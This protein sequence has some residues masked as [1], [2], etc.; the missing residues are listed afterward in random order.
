MPIVV[1]ENDMNHSRANAASDRRRCLRYPVG[2]PVMV[3]I[4]GLGESLLSELTD[5]S[6]GGCFLRGTELALYSRLGERLTFGFVL[7]GR[8]AGQVRGRVVRRAP[9]EGVGLVIEEANEAFD[10]LLS[11]LADNGHNALRFND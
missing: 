9:G 3:Q 11:A 4:E 2:L 10:E 6:T 5:V 1:F 7:R 8:E